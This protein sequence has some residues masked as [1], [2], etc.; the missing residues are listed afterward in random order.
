MTRPRHQ[1]VGEGA[2]GVLHISSISLVDFR[3]PDV[4]NASG[5][6]AG[7]AGP[8]SEFSNRKG[9]TEQANP[10]ALGMTPF[11]REAPEQWAELYEMNTFSRYFSTTAFL[12][13]LAKG[14]AC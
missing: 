11:D 14:S 2:N 10:K 8:V 13:F 1:K 9:A 12:G 6:S 7:H 5:L 3:D 4:T